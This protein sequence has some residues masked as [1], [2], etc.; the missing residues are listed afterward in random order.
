MIEFDSLIDSAFAA[1]AGL[2]IVAALLVPLNI[3]LEGWKWHRILRSTSNITRQD[4]IASILCGYTLGLL[5]P[6]RVGDYVGRVLY[7]NDGHLRTAFQTG[8]DRMISAAVYIVIGVS[9]L[10]A[11]LSLGIIEMSVSWKYVLAVG[12]FCATALVAIAAQPALLHHVLRSVSASIRWR[13]GIRFLKS[14][15]LSEAAGLLALSFVRYVVFITQLVLLVVAFGAET[16][17]LLL[18][19]AAALVFFVKTLIPSFTLADLGV[20]ET[21]SVF[22]FG[23]LGVESAA[24]LNA[25]LLLF[26]LNLVLPAIAGMFFVSRIRVQ[27]AELR[28]RWPTAQA[29]K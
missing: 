20:R 17:I 27:V 18:Y 10:I 6:A 3:A 11:A 29:F 19:L 15:D 8:L 9:A 24:A 4:A 16:S 25:A 28:W 14:F 5:T 7:L 2:L 1:D 21:A 22:F 23:L 26:S 12:V 13:A